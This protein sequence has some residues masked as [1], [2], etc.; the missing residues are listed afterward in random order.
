MKRTQIHSAGIV[1]IYEGL[2]GPQV[3]LVEQQ[4]GV[5][6]T[7]WVF[8]KGKQE[9][10]ESLIETAKRELK[11]EAGLDVKKVVEHKPFQVE[12]EFT[13]NDAIADKVVVGSMSTGACCTYV[14]IA[15]E[16]WRE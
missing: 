3:L 15:L 8:P 10:G 13:L 9:L 5:D 4:H 11:E 6:G 14:S 16:E 7:R 2:E 1:P 12:F